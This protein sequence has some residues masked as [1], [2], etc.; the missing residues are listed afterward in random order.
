MAFTE[1]NLITLTDIRGYRN[2]SPNISNTKVTD[3]IT[4]VQ[5][6]NLRKLFGEEMYYDLFN[7]ATTNNYTL[8]KSGTTYDYGGYTISY[9]GLKPYLCYLW[10]EAYALEGDFYQGDAGNFM[11]SEIENTQK[12]DYMTRKAIAS[13]FRDK[14]EQYK[15]DIIKYLNDNLASFP[16]YFGSIVKPDDGPDIIKF[17]AK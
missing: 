17:T 8:L 3:L 2:V 13:R 12:L 7:T 16:L 4:D 9:F 6:E 10:L 5:R 14:A 15:S 1:T 11:M